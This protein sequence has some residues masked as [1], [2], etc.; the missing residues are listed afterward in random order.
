MSYGWANSFFE[1]VCENAAQAEEINDIL[2]V[3]KKHKFFTSWIHG[4]NDAI[5]GLDLVDSDLYGSFDEDIEEFYKWVKDTYNLKIT[6]YMLEE[7]DGFHYRCE[8]DENGKLKSED[9]NW[10]SEYT[11]EQIREIKQWAKERFKN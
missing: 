5:L 10:I 2:N 3:P 4:N 1:I 9:L 7:V 6:G 11:L 8:F